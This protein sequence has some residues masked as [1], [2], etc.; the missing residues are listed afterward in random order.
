MLSFN[1]YFR[2]TAFECLKH[3][4]FD[5]VRNPKKEQMIEEIRNSKKKLGNDSPY[6]IQ[7]QVD[8]DEAFDYEN[9]DVV[10]YTVNDLK[11]I[12]AKEIMEIK[13]EVA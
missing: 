13:Q 7:L 12:L 2:M 9:S 5:P 8:R 6:F 1:P 3:K 4:I 11:N 10:K